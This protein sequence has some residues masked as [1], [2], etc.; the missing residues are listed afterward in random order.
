MLISECKKEEIFSIGKDL[1]CKCGCIQFKVETRMEGR[2]KEKVHIISCKKCGNR[3]EKVNLN[4]DI[5]KLILI[6]I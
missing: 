3:I 6:R 4:S 5:Y 2:S 1:K